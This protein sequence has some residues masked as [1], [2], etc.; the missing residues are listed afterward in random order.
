MK[1][2][3]GVLLVQQPHSENKSQLKSFALVLNLLL[4][5]SGPFPSMILGPGVVGTESAAALVALRG[6]I[7]GPWI[8]E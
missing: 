7:D 2:L 1:P 5:N 3:F 4:M 6:P 8:Q